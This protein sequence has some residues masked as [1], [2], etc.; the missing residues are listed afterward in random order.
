M[1][2]KSNSRSPV[3]LKFLGLMAVLLVIASCSSNSTTIRIKTD[4]SAASIKPGNRSGSAA[5]EQA[6]LAI[7]AGRKLTKDEV[8]SNQVNE[9]F[10]HYV[11]A[12]E[13]MAEGKLP[14]A[15]RELLSVTGL[16]ESKEGWT[17]L[18]KVYEQAGNQAKADS[19]K[20]RLAEFVRIQSK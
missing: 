18:I 13:F 1:Q 7:S 8:L 14:E 16:L 19:C 4:T 9:L 20:R 5:L 17:M 12:E 15:E 2:K 3:S 10:N 11:K 6:V